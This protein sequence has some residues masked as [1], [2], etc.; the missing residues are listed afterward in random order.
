[1]PSVAYFGTV[2]QKMTRLFG[3]GNDR[4][5]DVETIFVP[6]VRFAGAAVPVV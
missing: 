2:V 4:R 5:G 1:M 3:V 6:V